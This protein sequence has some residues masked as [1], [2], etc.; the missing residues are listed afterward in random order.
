MVLHWRAAMRLSLLLAMLWL[1]PLGTAETQGIYFNAEDGIWMEYEP[2]QA[3]TESDSEESPAA[4]MTDKTG[5]VAGYIRISRGTV[6]YHDA[7][8][9]QPLGYPL[10]ESVFYAV[11]KRVYEKGCLY[12]LRFDTGSTAEDKACEKAYYYS[13]N[14]DILGSGAKEEMFA[15][16]GGN[17][18]LEGIPIPYVRF[19]YGASLPE[20][21]FDGVMSASGEGYVSHD[22]TNLR[23][24]PGRTYDYVVQLDQNTKVTILGMTVNGVG[25]TW[26]YVRD[27]EGNQGYIQNDLVVSA[28]LNAS[29]ADLIEENLSQEEPGEA[30]FILLD[31]NSTPED[32]ETTIVLDGE[33]QETGIHEDEEEKEPSAHIAI[34]W[35]ESDD[36]N[37][38]EEYAVLSAVLEGY[39][40]KTY[41]LQWQISS[42]GQNW[43]DVDGAADKTLTV[44]LTEENAG[45]YWRVLV[46]DDET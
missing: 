34:Q 32:S 28:P 21:S 11:R 41:S 4:E 33:S 6:L 15:G 31:E 26:L 7:E 27:P 9:K 1:C 14:P 25:A 5:L 12:E 22:G 16:M 24:G 45:S 30:D 29:A 17:R 35:G 10:E 40:D 39:E 23:K 18:I 44:R 37:S 46:T 42:D 2:D 43:R 38:L 8:R 3:R 36:V 20:E 13:R 19:H